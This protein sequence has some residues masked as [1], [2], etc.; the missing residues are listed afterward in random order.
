M[1][2]AKKEAAKRTFEQSLARLEKIVDSLEQ[3]ETPLESAIE[4][5]EEGIARCAFEKA[6]FEGKLKWR[7]IRIVRFV[8]ATQ[9]LDFL[10]Q[11]I[12][13]HQRV[14]TGGK[15]CWSISKIFVKACLIG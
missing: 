10:R 11:K 13:W 12:F 3:G 8:A 5:Y 14:T 4:L 7:K 15:P 9:T 6:F 1:A 2:P